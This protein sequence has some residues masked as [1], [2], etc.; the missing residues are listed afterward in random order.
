MWTADYLRLIYRK[1]GREKPFVDC[2]GLYRVIVQERAGVVIPEHAAS[3]SFLASKRALEA[4]RAGGG[5][6]E[7]EPGAERELDL[8]L[9]WGVTGR[10]RHARAVPLHC[11][12]VVRPGLLIH[13]EDG[14]G[15]LVQQF[16]DTA[17]TGAHPR[18]RERVLGIYRPEALA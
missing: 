9:M 12:C 10:G 18:V 7:I 13:I 1:G 11:G 15:V 6:S 17:A 5:W 14:V 4:E 3:R 8:V 2:F 16:R